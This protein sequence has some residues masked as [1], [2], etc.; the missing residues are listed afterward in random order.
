VSATALAPVHRCAFH[1]G[2]EQAGHIAAELCRRAFAAGSP[3]VAHV[4]DVVRQVMAERVPGAPVT[5]AP[6]RTLVDVPLEVLAADWVRHLG[7][8]SGG[9]V[10]VLCQRP[11]ALDPDVERWRCA[12]QD[13]TAAVAA[14]P[15]A[16]TCLVDT[17]GPPGGVAMARGTH[18]V[19]WFD[20]LDLPNPDLRLPAVLPA[21]D[22]PVTKAVLDPRAAAANRRWWHEQ[23][24]AAGLPEGRRDELVLVLHECVTLAAALDGDPGGIRV[25]LSVTGDPVSGIEVTGEVLTRTRC[26]PLTPSA[27]PSDR[28]LLMLWLAEKVSPAVSLAVLPKAGG[29]RFLVSA[30]PPDRA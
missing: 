9:P 2:P 17:A 21:D 22:G 12:E 30:R 11:L 4:D 24:T 23:L 25:R 7:R 20:G 1:D 10:T 8:G 15:L 28:R 5:F 14:R 6:Q 13:T 3:V 16:V 26:D 29:T 27:V 18:P 19:L